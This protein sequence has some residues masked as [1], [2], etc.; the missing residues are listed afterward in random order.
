MAR[1]HGATAWLQWL[2]TAPALALEH[3]A[4]ECPPYR[5]RRRWQRFA[6]ARGF[7]PRACREVLAHYEAQGGA[8]D[9]AAAVQREFWRG[10][11]EFVYA[12]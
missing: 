1:P 3:D 7:A 11:C 8:A 10:V 9:E 2:R 4:L 5:L 6:A 12:P